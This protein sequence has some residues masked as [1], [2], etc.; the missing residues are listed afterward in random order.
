MIDDII[1]F[2]LKGH[3]HFSLIISGFFHFSKI[4]YSNLYYVFVWFSSYQ[5]VKRI[6]NL[7][8][9][10]ESQVLDATNDTTPSPPNNS[11][12]GLLLQK[13]ITN[14]LKAMKYQ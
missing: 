3:G 4:R 8:N 12:G 13:L 7:C 1:L 6:V 5:Y 2:V 14:V 11:L 9:H 10:D